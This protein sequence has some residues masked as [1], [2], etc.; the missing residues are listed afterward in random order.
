[1]CNNISLYLCNSFI[2]QQ[3]ILC[4]YKCIHIFFLSR[5]FVKPY[6]QLIK[7]DNLLKYVHCLQVERHGHV[8]S[9]QHKI[10]IPK[11]AQQLRK[12][13]L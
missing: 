9:Q 3:N 10:V 1:M 13:I 5:F 7:A 4:K 8:S 12:I 6:H 11:Q 2:Q